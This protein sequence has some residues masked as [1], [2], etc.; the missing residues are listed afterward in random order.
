MILGFHKWLGGTTLSEVAR[1]IPV[2]VYASVGEQRRRLLPRLL[3]LVSLTLVL[4]LVA[5]TKAVAVVP[6]PPSGLKLLDK[7]GVPS[8]IHNWSS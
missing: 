3:A 6:P 4:A 2:A 5:T 7:Y 8:G 1:K